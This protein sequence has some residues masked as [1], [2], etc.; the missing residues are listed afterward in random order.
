[1]VVKWEL[2]LSYGKIN[3]GRPKIF[4]ADRGMEVEG[5]KNN[6]EMEVDL[7]KTDAHKTIDADKQGASRLPPKK[8]KEQESTTT[9]STTTTSTTVKFLEPVEVVSTTVKEPS[10]D[11]LSNDAPSLDLGL[12]ATHPDV[13]LTSNIG[14]DLSILTKFVDPKQENERVKKNAKE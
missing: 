2:H 7:E 6:Q 5:E 8:A 4:E 11:L 14:H 3:E 13:N 12:T 1:M 9:A 10:S